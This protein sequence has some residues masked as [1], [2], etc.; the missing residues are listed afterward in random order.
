MLL[1]LL[2]ALQGAVTRPV[3][4]LDYDLTVTLPDAGK[5]IDGTAVITLRRLARGGAAFTGPNAGGGVRWWVADSYA[6][7]ALITSESLPGPDQII[8]LMGM[9]CGICVGVAPGTAL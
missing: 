2:L 9:G 6:E 3:D 8:R 1:S 7:P 4:V 5:T